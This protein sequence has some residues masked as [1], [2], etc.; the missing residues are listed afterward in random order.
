VLLEF[1]VKN[2]LA[3]V[4][5]LKVR[6]HFAKEESLKLKRFL[7]A[8]RNDTEPTFISHSRHGRKFEPPDQGGITFYLNFPIKIY[9]FQ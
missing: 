9:N 1:I 2:D 8:D 5:R 3:E 4:A 6:E 7:P